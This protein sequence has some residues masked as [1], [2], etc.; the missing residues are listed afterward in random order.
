MKIIEIKLG[1]KM[2]KNYNSYEASLTALTEEQNGSIEDCFKRLRTMALAEVNVGLEAIS[3][4]KEE[5]SK[6]KQ[7]KADK[8]LE[9]KGFLKQ[10][11]D[12]MK[13]DRTEHE[14]YRTLNKP[15]KN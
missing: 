3:H 14:C 10:P 8:F 2:T 12:I 15:W 13:C 1:V 7:A 5:A 11:K 6:E 9:D 4:Q